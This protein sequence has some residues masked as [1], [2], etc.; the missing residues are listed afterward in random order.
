M[1]VVNKISRYTNSVLQNKLRLHQ[2]KFRL[3]RLDIR[4]SIIFSVIHRLTIL[5]AKLKEKVKSCMLTFDLHNL[6]LTISNKLMS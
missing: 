2:G 4:N 6:S 3:N 1:Q 5:A